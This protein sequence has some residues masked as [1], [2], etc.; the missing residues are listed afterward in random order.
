MAAADHLIRIR[1]L[2]QHLRHI[3]LPRHHRV[4]LALGQRR[5]E[6]E[7]RPDVLDGELLVFHLGAAQHHLE[8]LVGGLPARQP[9]LLALEI[10]QLAALDAPALLGDDGERCVAIVFGGVVHDETDHLERL[11]GMHRLEVGGG[12]HVADLRAAVV[13]GIDHV[14]A[15]IDHQHL[16]VDAVLLEEALLRADEHRQMTEIISDHHVEL[17]QFHHCLYSRFF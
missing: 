10:G 6:A 1:H 9:D 7:L 3:G 14:G 2:R 11:A 16:G 4:D 5:G 12:A 13:H 8:I 17:G 15:G